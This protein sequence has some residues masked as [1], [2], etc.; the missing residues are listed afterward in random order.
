MTRPIL[1]Y[2]FDPLCGWCYGI[3]PAIR[4][5]AE[6]QPD[7]EIRL[8]M[9]GLATGDRVGPYALKTDYIRRVS[10]TLEA[11]TG[12]RPSEAFFDLIARPGV[13]GDS[14]PPAAA[15]AQVA[16]RTP[17]RAIAFAHAVIE[18]HFA[19]GMDL[20]DPATYPPLLAAAAPEV[21][22]VDLA[23][24]ESA[25]SAFD[26]GRALGIASF[27]T[28]VLAGAGGAHALPA[29][30]RPDA[31]VALVADRLA[32]IDQALERTPRSR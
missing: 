18:A 31:L 5:V 32:R 25:E 9:A 7:L 14:A 26:E 23:D 3:A 4:A 8:V 22:A 1:L 24:R 28:L 30:Y 27:P 11:V 19:D 6:A 29:E 13:I 12:R 10:A 21:A 20:G 15:I 2:G 16:R 17:H